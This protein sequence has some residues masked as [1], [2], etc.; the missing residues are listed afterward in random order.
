VGSSN[1]VGRPGAVAVHMGAELATGGVGVC[2][3]AMPANSALP[4]SAIAMPMMGRIL[5]SPFFVFDVLI[6]RGN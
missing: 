2:A 5:V 1:K 6:E 3:N 4:A